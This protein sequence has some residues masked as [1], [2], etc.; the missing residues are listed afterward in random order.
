MEGFVSEILRQDKIKHSK[1]G[2]KHLINI[3]TI[4]V[5]SQYKNHAAV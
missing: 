2:K 1:M 5:A 4:F 3:V